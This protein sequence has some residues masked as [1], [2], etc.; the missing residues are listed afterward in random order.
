MDSGQAYINSDLIV[1][2]L[3]NTMEEAL[4]QVHY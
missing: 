2:M 4:L 3:N 1:D